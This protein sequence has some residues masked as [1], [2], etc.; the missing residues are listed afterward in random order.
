MCVCVRP[1][2]S[3]EAQQVLQVCECV[4]E[5]LDKM[6]EEI[7]TN[8]S[9]GLEELCHTHLNE[10]LL[11]LDEESSFYSVNFNPAVRNIHKLTYFPLT[12]T[13]LKFGQV[14]SLDLLIKH[15]FFN[16]RMSLNY[17]ASLRLS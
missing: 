4:L 1:L 10:P 3:P 7:Y 6:D 12:S 5:V 8:W 13:V 9:V 17:L 2:D 11:I 15:T 16:C 14:S